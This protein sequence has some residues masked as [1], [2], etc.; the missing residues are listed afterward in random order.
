MKTMLFAFLISVLPAC[1]SPG[2]IGQAIVIH[3]QAGQIVSTF[4]ADTQVNFVVLFV[5]TTQQDQSLLFNSSQLYDIAIYDQRKN[6]VWNWAYNQ[7]FTQMQ[8]ELLILVNGAYF[9]QESWNMHTNEDVPVLPGNYAVYLETPYG[10]I[11]SG[12][13]TIKII[14]HRRIFRNE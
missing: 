4:L 3:N 13:H 14:S 8:K 2:P 12:P 5:N 6:L 7:H 10:D 1:L 11:V 9:F